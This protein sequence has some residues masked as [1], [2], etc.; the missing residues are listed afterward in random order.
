MYVRLL[1]LAG[2]VAVDIISPQRIAPENESGGLLLWCE[3]TEAFLLYILLAFRMEAPCKQLS[4]QTLPAQCTGPNTFWLLN[5][6]QSFL[7]TLL[8]QECYYTFRGGFWN[9]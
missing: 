3:R 1:L 9:N 6:I 4:G 8:L 5:L 7:L 2:P